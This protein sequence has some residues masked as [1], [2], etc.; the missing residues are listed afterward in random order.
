MK[1]ISVI[2]TLIAVTALSAG[3]SVVITPE[4]AGSA[5]G[6]QNVA[7]M[8]DAQPAA[9]PTA[10]ALEDPTGSGFGFY[11][12]APRAVYVDFG[13]DYGSVTIEQVWLALK[14]WGTN[15]SGAPQCFWSTEPDELFDGSDVAAPDF[16][17]GWE[18]NTGATQW[19]QTWSGSVTPQHQYYII[20]FDGT[21]GWTNR[22]LEA[23]FG[24]V[25]EPGTL[26]LLGLGV[27]GLL[28]RR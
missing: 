9:V 2:L 17:F 3:A 10:G 19:L 8:F 11:T 24:G 15:P 21:Q 6:Y 5:N 14:Q 28:R 20:A 18:E 13:A 27:A 22:S 26:C 16:F 4:G 7:G 1:H 12:T 25:P 23:V